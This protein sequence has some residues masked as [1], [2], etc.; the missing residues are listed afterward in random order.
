MSALFEGGTDANFVG[1]ERCVLWKSWGSAW[2]RVGEGFEKEGGNGRGMDSSHVFE[3]FGW[4]WS[5]A[6]SVGSVPSISV[7][8]SRF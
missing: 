2:D 6:V 5:W 4:E 8:M 1:G 7:A 3:R